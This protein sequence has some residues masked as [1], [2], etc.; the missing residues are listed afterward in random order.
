MLLIHPRKL[1]EKV[2]GNIG[3]DVIGH[4]NRMTINFKQ[5]FIKF[6]EPISVLDEGH[7]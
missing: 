4:F 5:M 7:N 3:Q 1:E 2:C 6:D